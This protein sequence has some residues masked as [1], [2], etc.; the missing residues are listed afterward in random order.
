MNSKKR[1]SLVGRHELREAPQTASPTNKHGH[2][3]K[4]L[5]LEPRWPKSQSHQ[6]ARTSAYTP[7]PKPNVF[8]PPAPATGHGKKES[9]NQAP[10]QENANIRQTKRPNSTPKREKGSLIHPERSQRLQALAKVQSSIKSRNADH[11][12]KTQPVILTI[13]HSGK[14]SHHLF[15]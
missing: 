7:T 9:T 6:E 11:P 13:N 4:P 5:T 3:L 2:P 8:K 10:S 14:R 12:R 1:Q 15:Y